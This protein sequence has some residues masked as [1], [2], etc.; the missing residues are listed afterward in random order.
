[1][2]TT[3][4]FDSGIPEKVKNISVMTLLMVIVFSGASLAQQ[5][6]D[7][8]GQ[9]TDNLNEPLP[10]ASVVVEGT[11]IGTSTDSEGQFEITAEETATLVFSYIGFKTQRIPVEGRSRIDVTLVE[12]E[13]FMDEIVY[14]GYGSTSRRKLS[15][16]I[17]TVGGERVDGIPI[18]NIGEGLK[19]Q[20]GG[21]RI[22]DRSGVP[23]QEPI[24][25]IRGG[26]SIN[27]SNEPLI[28][29]DGVER[30]FSDLNPNDIAEITV[31]KDAASTAIYGSRASNGVVLI[32]TKRG[33]RDQAPTITFESNT[34][35]Q[36]NI[37]Q[38]DLMNAREFLQF[39]RERLHEN[40]PSFN[41]FMFGD[42]HAM[43]SGNTEIS[44][45]TT[46]Y[47]QPG[48]EVPEGWHSMTDLYDPSRTL[49][50]QDYDY[51]D[52][53]F[54]RGL[55]Q[56]HNL[57]VA[58]G[59]DNI[60]YRANLGY[61]DDQGIA[62]SSGWSRLSARA[63]TDIQVRSN[64]TVSGDF[65]FS[66]SDTELFGHQRNA[67][68][69]GTYRT[70]NVQRPYWDDGTPTPGHNRTSPNPLWHDY[71]NENDNVERY[72]DV[73]GK[74]NWIIGGNIHVNLD[75]RRHVYNQERAEFERA[76]M[77]RGD[78]RARFRTWNRNR[79]QLD[80]DITHYVQRGNHSFSSMAGMSYNHTDLLRS[81]AQA[82][83]AVSDKIFTLNVAPEFTGISTEI[84]EEALLGYFGRIT[85]DYNDKYLLT[86]VFRADG[87]SRFAPENRWGYFP[88]GSAAW[89]VS[90]E[91]FME[92]FNTLS[93]LKLRSSYGLTG[94]NSV[95]LY[96]AFGVYRLDQPYAGN[97]GIRVSSMPN[98]DLQWES[99]RQLDVGLDFGLYDDRIVVAGDVFNK[100]TEQLLFTVPLPNSSGFNNIVQNV[101][102]VRY[103]GYEIEIATVN[104]ET[105]NFSWT[106]NFNWA[107]VQN[108]VVRL[109]DN[110][111]EGN[112]I[113]GFIDANG[114]AFGGIAEGEPLGRIYGYKVD[115]IIETQDQ[116][117]NAHFDERSPGWDP[118]DGTFEAGRKKIGDY[119]WVDRDGDNAITE[120]DQFKLGNEI[121]NTTGGLA[122]N[123]K[124]RNW[125]FNLVLDWALGH[126]IQDRA[127]QWSWMGV[128][129]QNMNIPREAYNAWEQPGDDTKWAKFT[130]AD[131]KLSKNYDRVS[132]VFNYKAD[133][134]AVREITIGYDFSPEFTRRFGAAGLHV[135]TSVN[136][137]H[138]FTA[139]E[140]LTPERG[141]A[142]TRSQ[143]NN[144]QGYPMAR[145]V[146][147][148]AKLS[149]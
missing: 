74:I 87:S 137:L 14:I 97:A 142:N 122:N 134:L 70:P 116:A 27:R 69:R 60:K 96:D 20:I 75:A 72:F 1:M 5:Q 83:G 117:D 131:N 109:P 36:E 16:S 140:G 132:D 64:V 146:T 51:Q 25:R 38:R 149:F 11:T 61:A 33:E 65:S 129:N 55:W 95:G 2:G 143:D 113:G 37:Q 110:D 86:G 29:V 103:R 118:R 108:E 121:P 22:Y 145:R 40:H 80:A 35:Y 128:F 18:S 126:S 56:N 28:L 101:G 62:L 3:I 4:N 8:S 114:N 94:N 66:Q 133:Y 73:G 41:Q 24:I 107:Y 90:E 136:N 49:I 130:S 47:L 17:S 106:T 100:L 7:I 144:N 84:T 30:S 48:E 54:Q 53:M 77:F 52:I 91:S 59:T 13:L 12:S 19:G 105:S 43:S 42:N 120:A 79:T 6:I 15:T 98:M 119:E 32:T 141:T 99:T 115:Y 78:R 104:V 111:L 88:G 23:G 148:G 31:L 112:R 68:A 58:G 71:I 124:Y 44:M 147:F 10:G 63:N 26:S 21:V 39:T 67:F 34:G 82:R 127:Y 50:F 93:F 135:Y 92:G 76:N 102:Q 138:Y 57:T 123:F 45:Y 85:Y 125:S 139:V 9:V 89:V 81:D 46:R